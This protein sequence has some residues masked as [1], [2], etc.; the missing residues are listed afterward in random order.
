M[1]SNQCHVAI[2]GAGPYGLSVAAFLKDKGIDFQIFGSP[3]HSWRT[4]MPKGMYL[5]S[6][7]FASNLH[8]PHGHFT[9]KSFCARTGR[10]YAD[11]GFAIP[12]DT[13]LAYGLAFQNELVPSLQERALDR[14]KK[15][16]DG[17]LLHFAD[18]GSVTARNVVLAV[19]TSYYRYIPESLAHLPG[20]LLSHSAAHHDLSGFRGRNVSVLGGGASALDL[21][22]LLHDAGAEVNLIVR[23]R[24]LY[25]NTKEERPIWRRWYPLCGLGPGVRKRFYAHGPMLFRHLP[26][27]K[28]LEIVRT[29]LGPAGGY[30]VRETVERL[31]PLLGHSI[32]SAQPHGPRLALTLVAT[33]GRERR[34][35]TDHLIAATGFR[36]DLQKLSLLSEDL[37]AQLAAPHVSAMLT[38]N[39]ESVVPGIHL[40]GISSAQSFGPVMRFTLGARYTARRLADH[41]AKL[42]KLKVLVVTQSGV[43]TEAAE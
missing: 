23:Q 9:L 34:L 43:P 21:A 22:A 18:G 28:R 36:V 26:L 37:K 38:E 1:M 24:G 20:E 6:E 33:D 17:F 27:E 29:T 16:G 35:E 12:L 42:S 5:K 10:S 25:W 7:G 15:R 32:K 41:F 31:P 13:F 4:E 19:G 3:M 40:A 39:F 11:W 2:V 30:P 8:D 14:L